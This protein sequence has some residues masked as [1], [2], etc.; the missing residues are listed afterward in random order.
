MRDRPPDHLDLLDAMRAKMR[1]RHLSHRT[2]EA[3]VSWA[4]RFIRYHR[5]THPARLRS[6]DIDS[7]LTHLSARR[8]VA[9]STHNQAASALLFMYR[10]VLGIDVER[11]APVVRARSPTR[12]P[13]VLTPTEVRKV[14]DRMVAVH[15][16]LGHRNVRSTMIYT[17]VL[18]RG[19]L[20]VK[21]PAD[22]L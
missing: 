2:E 11:P 16:L 17:H 18:N 22:D 4:R 14:L 5:G 7:F 1:A 19:G 10:H 3:Y 12:L 6:R 21:S 9:A 20:G 15:R 13:V 8:G